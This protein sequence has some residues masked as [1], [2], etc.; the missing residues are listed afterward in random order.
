M[1]DN[2]QHKRL[3]DTHERLSELLKEKTDQLAKLR[4]ELSNAIGCKYP[5]RAIVQYALDTQE[6]SS[7]NLVKASDEFFKANNL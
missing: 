2:F 5:S 1:L 3:L 4:N 6:G 7:L